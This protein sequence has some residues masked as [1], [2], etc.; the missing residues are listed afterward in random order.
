MQIKNYSLLL[1]LA[2]LWGPSFMFIKIAV[3]EASPLAISSFRII[4]GAAILFLIL[5]VRKAALSKGNIPWHFFALSGFFNMALPYSLI[6]WGEQYIDSALAGILNGLTPFFTLFI[7]YFWN[8]EEKLGIYKIAGALMGFMGLCL[9]LFP[10]INTGSL[11]SVFGVTLVAIAAASYGLAAVYIKKKLT[12]L[13]PLIA[14]AYQLLYASLILSPVFIVFGNPSAIPE[15]DSS[16][17]WA[18]ASLGF[19]GTAMAYIVYFKIIE[20]TDASF[21]T[22]VTYLMPVIS[23]ILGIVF[24]DEQIYWNVYAGAALIVLGLIVTNQNSPR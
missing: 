19:F 8:K 23:V 22:L 18:I 24:L 17:W 6:S 20:R 21:L 3:Q 14:P 12:G 1:L 5:R 16:F 13:K 10:Y 9:L 11:G 4:I 7:T 15:V 2:C